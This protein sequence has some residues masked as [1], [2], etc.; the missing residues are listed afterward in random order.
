MSLRIVVIDAF[1]SNEEGRKK[2]KTFMVNGFSLCLNADT[3]SICCHGCSSMKR[4][5][6]YLC[7]LHTYMHIYTHVC[8]PQRMV[9]AALRSVSSRSEFHL[10]MLGMEDLQQFIYDPGTNERAK[11]QALR[12]FTAVDIT[13]VAGDGGLAPWHPRAALLLAYINQCVVAGANLVGDEVVARMLWHLA[14]VNGRQLLVTDVL[15]SNGSSDETASANMMPRA[16]SGSSSV[17]VDELSGEAFQFE[18]GLIDDDTHQ[19]SHNEGERKPKTRLLRCC[20]V[21]LRRRHETSMPISSGRIL[22]ANN[23]CAAF[24]A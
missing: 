9:S 4:P 23:F 8:A 16:Y 14:C 5:A 12:N 3:K 15:N 11:T 20:N 7:A 1:P 10:I 21:G 24:C 22:F 13:F 19:G 2:A 6:Y 17:M 18:D